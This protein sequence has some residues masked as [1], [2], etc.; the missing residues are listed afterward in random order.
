MDGPEGFLG[1]EKSNF[2]KMPLR[3]NFDRV[4]TNVVGKH[5]NLTTPVL[6]F[7]RNQAKRKIPIIASKSTNTGLRSAPIFEF[8]P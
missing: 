8:F 4:A 6:P 1:E 7:S 2:L 3:P 5:S